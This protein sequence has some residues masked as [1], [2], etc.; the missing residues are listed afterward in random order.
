LIYD[1]PQDFYGDEYNEAEYGGVKGFYTYQRRKNIIAIF[2]SSNDSVQDTLTTLRHEL[3]EHFGLNLFEPIEKMAFLRHVII[4]SK[5]KEISALFDEVGKDYPDILH[6]EF[7]VA[8]EVFTE[9]KQLSFQ[10]GIN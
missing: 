5:N 6:D 10:E 1:S 8:E 2:R 9:L 4:S 3:L 7:L